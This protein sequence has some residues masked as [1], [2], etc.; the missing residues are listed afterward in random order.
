MC[1]NCDKK[2]PNFLGKHEMGLTQNRRVP[3]YLIGLQRIEEATGM[4]ER[5]KVR[6]GKREC[7][8]MW[9]VRER[10]REREWHV[11]NVGALESA[12]RKY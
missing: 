9:D 5:E 10:E 2:P 4:R 1:C 12:L 11:R 8:C 7:V 3:K 6:E